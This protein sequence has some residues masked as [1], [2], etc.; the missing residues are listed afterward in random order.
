MDEIRND[1][2]VVISN[3]DKELERQRKY[4]IILREL[5][6]KAWNWGF[7]PERA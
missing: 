5:T 6:I 4:T 3:C 2:Q 7:F 1:M